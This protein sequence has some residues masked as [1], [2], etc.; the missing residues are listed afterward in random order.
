MYTELLG[1]VEAML[2]VSGK[3]WGQGLGT[4]LESNC[5]RDSGFKSVFRRVLTGLGLSALN[6]LRL[7]YMCNSS[8]DRGHLGLR[9]IFW[10]AGSRTSTAPQYLQDNKQLGPNIHGSST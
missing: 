7:Q 2:K 10:E 1:D 5:S 4:F 6:I 9:D 8:P 3:Y